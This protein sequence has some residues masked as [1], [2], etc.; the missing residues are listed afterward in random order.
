[1]KHIEELTKPLM[2]EVIN[3]L[4]KM[5]ITEKID[6]SNLVFGYDENG[7]FYTSRSNKGQKEQFFSN[8]DYGDSPVNNAFKAA[9][10][11]LSA[12]VGSKPIPGTSYEIEILYGRQPNAV[13]YGSNRIVF[14][15]SFPN[16]PLETVTV[17]TQMIFTDDGISL[18]PKRVTST[19]HF[20]Q[21]PKITV[22]GLLLPPH[23]EKEDIKT[24]LIE[25]ILRQIK[26]V[27]RNVS[28]LLPHEDFGVEGIVI[29]NPKTDLMVKL[30]DKHTF[31][32]INQ[33]NYAIRN[34][35][36]ST[37]PRFNPSKNHCLFQTFIATVGYQNASIYDL[38]LAEIAAA[39]G[40]SGMEKY[41]TITRT[42]KKYTSVANFIS[43][44]RV[45]H[46]DVVKGPVDLA[47]MRAQ[48][49]LTMARNVFIHNWRS[50][51]LVLTTGRTI[52]YTDE[53]Y[54]RTL[55]VFAEVQQELNA[56]HNKIEKSTTLT[57]IATALY[58]KQIQSAFPNQ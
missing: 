40:M 49:R 26:P 4:G 21:V 44:W 19:W 55:L 43:S 33:F 6:G 16:I 38:M 45:Q 34:E 39:I 56:L 18:Y 35:I 46:I 32:L 29:R 31:T 22:D 7:Q 23:Y 13:V 1:M 17:T 42:L 5:E 3:N 57:D 36:K 52:K 25:R 58:S 37:G 2:V 50:Y 14:I 54:K 20:S 27:F 9:H 15:D 8:E 30:V 11:A 24:A 51:K 10:A 53:I 28:D 41:L 48:T 12:T 47:V